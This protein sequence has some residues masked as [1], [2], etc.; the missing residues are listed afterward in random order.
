V[1]DV[2]VRKVVPRERLKPAFAGVAAADR[3]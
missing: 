2:Q 1:P 3:Q